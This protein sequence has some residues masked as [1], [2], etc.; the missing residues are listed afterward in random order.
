MLS[1]NFAQSSDPGT[2][3]HHCIEV[4][5]SNLLVMGGDIDLAEACSFQNAV[6]AIGIGER[7][8]SGRVRVLSGL[9]RQMSGRGPERQDVERVLLQRPPA[10]E[11]QSPIGP[12]ASTNVDKRRGRVSKEHHAEPREG[13]IERGRLK[14][15]HLGICVD[16]MHSFAALR[17]ALRE[18]QHRGRQIDPYD[19]SLRCDRP[20]KVQRSLTSATAYVQNALTRL[21]RQRG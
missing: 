20:D 13:S 8:W 11:S 6:H 7:E 10:D 2:Y 5:A 14:R 3:R 12:E 17:C 4:A 9:R 19:R 15:E 21:R 16:E 18:R 1:K